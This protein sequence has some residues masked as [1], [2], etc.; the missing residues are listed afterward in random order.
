[1][2]LPAPASSGDEEEVSVALVDG[3]W[4]SVAHL[5][6]SPRVAYQVEIGGMTEVVAARRGSDWERE[7]I[8]ETTYLGPAGDGNIDVAVHSVH[9][10]LW[11]DWI[12]AS[13][14]MGFLVQDPETG[15]WSAVQTE[16]YSA[17]GGSEALARTMARER[18]QL[19]VLATP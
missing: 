13:G 14:V 5:G 11:V 2:A 6:A 10:R 17:A 1:M 9:D 8:H 18:I 7:T 12:E 3:Q 15:E 16:P 4:S 19:R